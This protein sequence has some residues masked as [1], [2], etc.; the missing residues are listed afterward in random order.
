MKTKYQEPRGPCTLA[1][2]AYPARLRSV[3]LKFEYEVF[4]VGQSDSER[5]VTNASSEMYLK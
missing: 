1:A 4:E 3:G 5:E 2:M